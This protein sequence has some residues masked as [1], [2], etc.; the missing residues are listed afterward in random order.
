MES[1]GLLVLLTATRV[2]NP[3]G[4]CRVSL[5]SEGIVIAGL[6]LESRRELYLAFLEV[7]GYIAQLPFD[8]ELIVLVE[9]VKHILRHGLN[10]RFLNAI[11]SIIE[12]SH[13][14]KQVRLHT[15]RHD[16]VLIFRAADELSNHL[17][18][19]IIPLVHSVL[20]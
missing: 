9:Y 13:Q 16:L 17:V 14:N 3:V 10:Y 18:D 11:D 1:A 5:H 12:V 19:V 8:V 15:Q 6:A 4:P 20:P 2:Q 7:L